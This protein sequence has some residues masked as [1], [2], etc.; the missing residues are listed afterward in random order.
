MCKAIM[1]KSKYSKKF[2]KH[3]VI[4]LRLSQVIIYFTIRS[5][6]NRKINISKLL[7]Q[8]MEKIIEQKSLLYKFKER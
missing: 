5:S 6:W 7:N 8:Q 2:S 1:L 3:L 4:D